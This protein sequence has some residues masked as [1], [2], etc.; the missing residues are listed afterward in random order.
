MALTITEDCINCGACEPVC[1]NNAI[2]E[3]GAVWRFSDKTSL[4]GNILTLKGLSA[5]AGSEQPT[6]SDD[7]F[8]IVADKCTEC[9]GFHDEP[10]CIAECPVDCI[11]P[12]ENHSENEEE[13]LAKKAWLHG[14]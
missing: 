11:V 13:L 6:I 3:N 9:K 8:F 5:D 12:D 1:P 10:Q 7:Y 4:F 2:Y 14:E